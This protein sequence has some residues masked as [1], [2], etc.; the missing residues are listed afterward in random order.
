MKPN[1]A[2]CKHMFITF[3]PDTP[4]GC[5]VYQIQTSSTPSLVVKKANGGSECIGFEPKE[6]KE[7]SSKEKD[8]N[9]PKYWNS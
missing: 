5:R 2:S 4:R 8:L 9:D 7:N 1:C 6:P 3:N